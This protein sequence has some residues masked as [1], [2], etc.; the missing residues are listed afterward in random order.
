MKV[1]MEE[2]VGSVGTNTGEQ[3]K[4]R[5]NYDHNYTK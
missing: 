5:I 2:R 1:G 3:F 4:A